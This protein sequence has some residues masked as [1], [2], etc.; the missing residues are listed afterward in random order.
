MLGG[1][2]KGVFFFSK[3]TQHYDYKLML[4]IVNMTNNTTIKNIH[5]I[6]NT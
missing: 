3:L 2:E 4:F 5:I 6:R 1:G